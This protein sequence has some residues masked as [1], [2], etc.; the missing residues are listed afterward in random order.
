MQTFYLI[1][2]FIQNYRIDNQIH[3]ANAHQLSQAI[4][5]N[6]R[7]TIEIANHLT[8]EIRKEERLR[9]MYQCILLTIDFMHLCALA[10]YLNQHS[11]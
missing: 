4:D 7:I 6:Q 3:L 1:Y 5:E 11:Q 10:S 2:R 9:H 8:Q